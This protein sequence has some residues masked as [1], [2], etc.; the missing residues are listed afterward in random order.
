M[1]TQKASIN[2]G[3]NHRGNTMLG[4]NPDRDYRKFYWLLAALVLIP[5]ILA[6]IL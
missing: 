6:V 1:S 2:N 5:I 4:P 3:E